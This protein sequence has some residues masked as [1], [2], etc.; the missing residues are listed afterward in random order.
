MSDIVSL[1]SQYEVLKFT[2]S[3]LSTLDLFHLGFSNTHLYGLI[4]KSKTFFKLLTSHNLCD[5][6]GLKARQQF[7]GLYALHPEDH[8]NNNRERE[9]RYDE[10]IEVRVWNLKCDSTNALPCLKCNVNICEVR[11]G[12]SPD[13]KHLRIGDDANLVFRSAAMYLV[14]ETS[15]NTGLS[16]KSIM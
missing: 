6:R 9:P 11:E 2:A 10:E 13:I 1:L 8:L 4:L 12:Y 7:K 3:H 16:T 14:S 15:Q 5:G